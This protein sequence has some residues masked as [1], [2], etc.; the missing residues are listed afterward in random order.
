MILWYSHGVIGVYSLLIV[1]FC[2]VSCEFYMCCIYEYAFLVCFGCVGGVFVFVFFF[3]WMKT[4]AVKFDESFVEKL[5]S[6]KAVRTIS[7][8]FCFLFVRVLCVLYMR[9]VRFQCVLCSANPK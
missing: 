7:S 3:V 2:M 4:P 8:M 9:C 1:F 6:A 5:I